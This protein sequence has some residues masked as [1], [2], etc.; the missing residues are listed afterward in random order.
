MK[1]EEFIPSASDPC[2]AETPAEG[3]ATGSSA[4]F[5]PVHR[6]SEPAEAADAPVRSPKLQF[7]ISSGAAGL[8]RRG[9]GEREDLNEKAGC[10]GGA[11]LSDPLLLGILLAPGD[12]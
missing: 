12:E 3:I 2:L 7:L 10:G 11:P 8:G 9:P 5:G 6:A 4:T 1:L